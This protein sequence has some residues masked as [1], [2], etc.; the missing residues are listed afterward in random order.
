M[1]VTAAMFTL[2]D[3]EFWLNQHTLDAQRAY[4]AASAGANAYLYQL[5]ENPNF[6]ATCANNYQTMTPI[7][8]STT[9]EQYSFTPVLANGSTTCS[10]PR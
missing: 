5:N 2:I 3:G 10:T 9:S 1:L 6:W 7:P 4:D 8:G